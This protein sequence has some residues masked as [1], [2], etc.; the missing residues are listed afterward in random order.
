MHGL[1]DL[2]APPPRTHCSER[3]RQK[4]VRLVLFFDRIHRQKIFSKRFF[5][6]CATTK[7][8]S[9]I[10]KTIVSVNEWTPTDLLSIRITILFVIGEKNVEESKIFIETFFVFFEV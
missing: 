8:K 9:L 6:R 4:T 10:T 3:L 1:L 7:R 2:S 5:F